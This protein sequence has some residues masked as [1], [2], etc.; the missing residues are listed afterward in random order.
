M[1]V[2]A[3]EIA[4]ACELFAGLGPLTTRKMMSA[5]AFTVTA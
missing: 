3:A 2:S 5:S 4:F 1:S